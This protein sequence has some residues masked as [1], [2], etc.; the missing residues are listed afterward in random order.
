MEQ[1]QQLLRSSGMPTTAIAAAAGYENLSYFRISFKG[2]FGITP[3]QYRQLHSG[4]KD[5]SEP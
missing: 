4:G 2:Y 5:V 3:S 1:A